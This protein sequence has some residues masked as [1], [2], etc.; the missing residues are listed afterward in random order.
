MSEQEK[1]LL[2]LATTRELL[3]ELEAR[4]VI[5]QALIDDQSEETLNY[6]TVDVS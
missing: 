6:R 2:G 4:G 1:A 3:V 5:G